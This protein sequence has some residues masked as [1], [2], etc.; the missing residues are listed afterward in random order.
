MKCFISVLFRVYF[1]FADRLTG[2]VGRGR[3]RDNFFGQW[4]QCGAVNEVQHLSNR[5]IGQNEGALVA[6]GCKWQKTDLDV[7]GT[8]GSNVDCLRDGEKRTQT[9]A[10]GA[11]RKTNKTSD[12]QTI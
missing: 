6:A 3:Q 1:N 4:Q 9:T 7:V 12:S 10:S 2:A 11:W 8:V 5:L